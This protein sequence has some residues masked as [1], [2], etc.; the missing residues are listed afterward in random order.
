[1]FTG[2]VNNRTVKCNKYLVSFVIILLW[3]NKNTIE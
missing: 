2:K 3:A 1:M